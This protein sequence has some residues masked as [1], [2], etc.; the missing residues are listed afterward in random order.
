[1]QS[2]S[3]ILFLH[4]FN[5]ISMELY[6]KRLDIKQEV[7]RLKK[8]NLSIGFVPTM[9]ALH[10]GH[11]AL[12]KK[13]LENN[14]A[15]FVSIFVNPTQFNNAEDLEKYPRT[16]EADLNLLSDLSLSIKVF[17]PTPSE[18]YDGEM[19]VTSYDFEGLEYEMEGKFRPGH[20][21]GVG[22]VVKRLFDII[23]PDNAYFGEKDYQQLQIIKKLV[24]IERLSIN[25]VGC[26][27]YRED[28]GLALS[29]RNKRLTSKQL[30]ASPKIYKILQ[31]VRAYFGTKSVKW[32][33]NWVSEQFNNDSELK[34]EYFEIA[35]ANDLKSAETKNKEL[36]YRAFIAVF[37]GEVRLIDNI[38]LN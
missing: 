19:K 23:K 32:L 34:L 27:I 10:K 25:I 22:T 21:D 33:N 26:P 5:P 4:A 14:D 37:A 6:T 17:A 1:M 15:V 16:L 20:F 28:S 35:D 31:E 30:E 36:K 18:V 2:A 3:N 13:A 24:G 12:V 8:E 9:G 29:S 38:A 7:A 11:L